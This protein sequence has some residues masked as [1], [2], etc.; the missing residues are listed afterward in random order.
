MNCEILLRNLS[1][2]C[3]RKN[4]EKIN[5]TRRV[6]EATTGKEYAAYKGMTLRL[7]EDFSSKQYK[8]KTFESVGEEVLLIQN[9]LLVRNVT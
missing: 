8:H 9:Y 3:W 6:L 5:L 7:T 1:I 2:K 4:K